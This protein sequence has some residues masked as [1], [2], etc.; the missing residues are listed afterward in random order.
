MDTIDDAKNLV[1]HANRA[2]FKLRQEYEASLL[3]KEIRAELLIEIK[4]LMENLRSA[5]DYTAHYLF[6]K[7]GRSNR[8]NPRIYFPYAPLNQSQTQFQ[9]KK[10]IDACIPG[11]SA[12]R[13]DIVAKLESYQCF[14]SPDNR[15][16]PIFMELNNASKHQELTPQEKRVQKQLKI[17]SRGATMDMGPGASASLGPGSDIKMGDIRVPGRQTFSADNPPVVHGNGHVTVMNWVSFHFTAN[18][19]QVLPFLQCALNG[20]DHIIN[21]LAQY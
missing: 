14:A 1:A 4:N 19:E 12:S 6:G 10:R 8:P 7:F 3:A 18:G 13:P 5:L 15:W 16:L 11:L 17:S 9:K 20:V 21:E 2:F